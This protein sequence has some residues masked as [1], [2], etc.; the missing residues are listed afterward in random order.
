MASNLSLAVAVFA[1][2]ASFARLL[3]AI[4]ASK[5]VPAFPG[6]PET[7]DLPK[8]TRLSVVVPARDEEPGLEPALASLLAQDLPNL[9]VVLVDDRST[10]GTGEIMARFAR[11]RRNVEVV[12][13]E[14]LP[15]GWLGKNHA[16]HT[17]VRRSGGDWLLLT[18][19]DIRFRP[20]TLRRA[21]A[22]AGRQGLDHLALTPRWEL[23][24]Y[25]LRGVVAFFSMVLLLYGGYY[26][27][28]LPR[29]KKGVG[30]GAFNLIRHSAYEK[31]GGYE[32]L[33]RRPDDDLTLGSRV[34][35][36][37]LHQ[38]VLLGHQL[39]SVKWY[40]SLSALARGLEKNV[41]AGLDYSLTKFT[42][43]SLLLVLVGIWPFF[44]VFVSGGY[45]LLLYLAAVVAQL[46]A[47]ALINRFLGRQLFLLTAGYPVFAAIL[48]G[49]TVRSTLLTLLRGGVYW[50]GT[51]YPTSLLRDERDGEPLAQKKSPS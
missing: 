8:E 21:V 20:G 51:F 4:Y 24:G 23:S 39:I 13:V 17:G 18:D 33:A 25:W 38:R 1:A 2:I 5:L 40:G 47:Y 45:V 32:S 30:V 31:V 26:R 42:L 27:A 28:N 46:S 44:A 7:P 14:Q 9:E 49:I 37:G 22:Y 10:D 34:K 6:S 15:E 35:E 43:Y 3:E 36:A 16:I 11:D 19:A 50:R 12:R 48:A 29:S 41:Y